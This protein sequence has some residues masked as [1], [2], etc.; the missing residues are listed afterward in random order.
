MNHSFGA[1]TDP[2]SVQPRNAKS[3]IDASAALSMQNT[4]KNTI[5]SRKVAALIADGFDGKQLETMKKA[6]MAAGGCSQD[7]GTSARDH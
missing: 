7:R 3:S 2:K 6:L 4:V 5:K 1:D